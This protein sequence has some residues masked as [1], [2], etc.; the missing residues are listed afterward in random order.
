MI[1]RLAAA[2]V[3]LA[4]LLVAGSPA[5]GAPRVALEL[6]ADGL[7]SPVAVAPLPDG[8]KLLA[9]QNGFVRLLDRDGRLA[10]GGVPVLDFAGRLAAL[11]HGAFDERGLLCVATH[12]GV[13]RN[14]RVFVAYNAPRRATAPADYDCTL[15]LSE[16]A[17]EVGDTVRMDPSGERVLLE[18]DKPYRNHN[19][20]R[21]AFGPDGYLYMSVGDGGNANDQGRRPATGN[22]QDTFNLLGKI[23]RLDVDGAKP[24]DIPKDNP[25]ADGKGGRQEIFAYGL[26]NAWGLAF[27]RG[28][29]HE[30]F[31]V[32]V[33][34]NLFEEI[35]IVRKGGNYG[36]ALRE[37]FHGFDPRS[38]N[39]P[40]EPGARSG[41]RGE[42]LVDP[43]AEYRHPG[44]RKDPGAV[45]VSIIG[46]HVYRGKALPALVG[47]YVCAD[48]SRGWAMPQGRLLVARRPVDGTARWTI[49]PI[50]VS[51]PEKWPVYVTALGE[52]ADGELFVMT[53]GSNG[54]TPGKGRVWKM[55]APE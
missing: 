14:H 54:L 15:R 7:V 29:S 41:V 26:R 38:P 35:D 50:E 10:D 52:D 4:W 22:A 51:K 55:R 12:P 17:L 9:D 13:A 44:P 34:Q 25:F 1:R 3:G 27:D 18:I 30:L 49:E 33:G 39:N 28:G 53:N 16:F 8:R 21:L 24:F 23:L 46:G 40:P 47:H 11:N 19:G 20:A 5:H 6:V 42:P 36:W 45:G 32:D 48:W 2:S 43:I 37:G 31:A